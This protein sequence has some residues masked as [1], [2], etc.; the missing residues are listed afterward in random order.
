MPEGTEICCLICGYR[1]PPPTDETTTQTPQTPDR[2]LI[3]AGATV[4]ECALFSCPRCESVY[5]LGQDGEPMWDIRLPTGLVCPV[6]AAPVKTA[7]L[8]SHSW[9]SSEISVAC[10]GTIDPRLGYSVPHSLKPSWDAAQGKLRFSP[11]DRY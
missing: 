5:D 9:R 2:P 3:E 10:S 7:P 1:F 8:V 6:C 11:A 4:T